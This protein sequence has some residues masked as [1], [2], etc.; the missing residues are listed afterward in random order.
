MKNEF[1]MPCFVPFFALRA[2]ILLRKTSHNS[3][4]RKLLLRKSY[5]DLNG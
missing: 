5:G 4:E 3:T 2:K 1:F